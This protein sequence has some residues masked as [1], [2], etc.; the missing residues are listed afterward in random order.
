MSSLIG[1]LFGACYLAFT[2]PIVRPLVLAFG[3]PEMFML[4][5]LGLTCISTLS[6][7]GKGVFYWD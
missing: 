4:I 7:T 1:A 6:V 5:I 2:I 3:S